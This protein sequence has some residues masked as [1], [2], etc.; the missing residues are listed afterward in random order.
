MVPELI[1]DFEQTKR[2]DGE[3]ERHGGWSVDGKDRRNGDDPAYN[4]DQAEAN[5]TLGFCYGRR[6]LQSRKRVPK[7]LCAK[8]SHSKVVP[9]YL[10]SPLQID[11]QDVS[12]YTQCAWRR[13]LQA[14]LSKV[15]PTQRL[16][17]TPQV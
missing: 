14:R 6:N 17:I 12:F 1:V 4:L 9:H 13:S 3:R 7:E 16:S 15:F 10:S 8:S 2:G 11:H 5:A